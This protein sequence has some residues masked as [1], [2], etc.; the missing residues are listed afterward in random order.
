MSFPSWVWLYFG[1][2][3]TAG[4]VLF[5]LTAWTWM[6]FLRLAEGSQRSAAKWNM[7]GLM[8]LFV[9]AYFAC[10][11]G[12]PPGGLLSHDQATHDLSSAY[13]SAMLS[14]FF[15]VPGWACVLVGVRKMGRGLRSREGTSLASTR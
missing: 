7:V 10:G 12:G 5:T 13:D 1:T 15:S 8:F 14:I 11:I 6:K 2:F 3:G 9:A 4:A